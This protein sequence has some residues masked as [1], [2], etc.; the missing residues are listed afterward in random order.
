[1]DISKSIWT[2]R[3]I[4]FIAVNNGYIDMDISI[5]DRP[6]SIC[7]ILAMDISKNRYGH[8]DFDIFLDRYVHFLSMDISKMDISIWPYLNFSI[9]YLT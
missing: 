2:Y 9:A 5:S 8:I 6:R 7:P 4:H 1:M 3:Y